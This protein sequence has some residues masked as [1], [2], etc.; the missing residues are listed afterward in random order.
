MVPIFTYRDERKLFALIGVIIVAASIALIQLDSLKTGKPSLIT[1]GVSSVAVFAQSATSAVQ[2]VA[3]GVVSSIADAP[4]LQ[5]ENTTLR[6][7]N[8][9]LR[10]ENARLREAL[11][12]APDA[13]AIADAAQRYGNGVEAT[14]VGFDP[15]ALTRT[16][17]I[18][19]GSS[20]GVAADDGVVDDDGVVGR[21]VAVEPLSSTVLLVTDGASKVPAIVQRGRW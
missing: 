21:I 8:V 7:R 11:S 2:Q 5:S 13:R 6:A 10:R 12:E 4:R 15:E 9:D 3:R 18:D 19:R 16:V 17:T 14:V 1:V 20:S